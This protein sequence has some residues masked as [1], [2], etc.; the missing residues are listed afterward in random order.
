[1]ATT[2]AQDRHPVRHPGRDHVGEQ[3]PCDDRAAVLNGIRGTTQRPV[4]HIFRPHATQHAD[5]GDDQGLKT[6]NKDG[7]EQGRQEGGHHGPHDLFHRLRLFKWGEMETVHGDASSAAMVASGFSSIVGLLYLLCLY[8]GQPNKLNQG[9]LG[10]A[11]KGT[12]SAFKTLGHS[13]GIVFAGFPAS[14]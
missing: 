3:D 10:R 1:M 13:E 2:P 7:Q 8:L 14:T 12:A 4:G 9:S 6:E 5:G 11:D